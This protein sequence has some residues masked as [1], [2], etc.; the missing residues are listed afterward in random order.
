[1]CTV[2]GARAYV[3]HA[4]DSIGRTADVRREHDTGVDAARD[5]LSAGDDSQAVELYSGVFTTYRPEN[6]SA[7]LFNFYAPKE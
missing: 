7:Y 5:I 1:M 2:A 4:V 3:M 6:T